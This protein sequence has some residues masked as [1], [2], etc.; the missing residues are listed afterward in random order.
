MTLVGLRNINAAF[1][2][3]KNGYFDRFKLIGKELNEIN[4]GVLGYGNVGK[5]FVKKAISLGTKNIIVFT[6][7]IGNYKKSEKFNSLKI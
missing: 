7:D 1:N 4:I 5:L 2:N 3:T 6:K